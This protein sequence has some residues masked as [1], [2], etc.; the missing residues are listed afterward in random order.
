MHRLIAHLDGNLP[1][2]E[3]AVADFEAESGFCVPEDYAAFL[4]ITH[5]GEGCV[6]HSTSV[7]RDPTEALQQFNEAYRVADYTPCLYLIGSDGGEEAFGFDT[8]KE[9]WRTLHRG[10]I[11]PC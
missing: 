1:A 9:P 7:V 5:G 11:G 10:G 4:R 8:S 2:P 6:S 3:K